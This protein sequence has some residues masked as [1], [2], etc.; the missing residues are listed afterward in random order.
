M[1]DKQKI[2]IADVP[3]GIHTLENILG[4]SAVLSTAVSTDQAQKMLKKE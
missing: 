3:V 2:L 1:P 4:G